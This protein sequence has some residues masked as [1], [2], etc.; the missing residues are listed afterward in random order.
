[1]D[2]RSGPALTVGRP[3]RTASAGLD[4]VPGAS[5]FGRAVA[6]VILGA[7]AWGM[8]MMLCAVISLYLRNRLETLHLGKI[9]AI[10]FAGGVLAW[11]LVLA[12]T[13]LLTRRRGSE[14][15]FAAAFALL[16][17]GTIAMTAFLFAMDYRLFY[18]QWHQPFGTRTWMFQFLF[19]ALGA[20]YQFTVMGLGLYLPAGLPVL[21]G[22]SLWLA[23][24]AR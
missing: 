3:H 23:R 22:A 12:L 6:R 16:S 24:T 10:F 8:L 21:A 4:D 20:S 9:A 15:R 2:R 14:T 1:M 13:R 7:V 17:L 5:S 19:T 11:P 18:A